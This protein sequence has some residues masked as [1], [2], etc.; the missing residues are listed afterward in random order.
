MK[1]LLYVLAFVIGWFGYSAISRHPKTEVT[2]RLLSPITGTG[3]FTS[4]GDATPKMSY[5]HAVVPTG[6]HSFEDLRASISKYPGF[7][8]TYASMTK[9]GEDQLMYTGYL[10]NGKI[11]WT[12]KKV[13]IR[14]DEDIWTDGWMYIRARCGNPLSFGPRAPVLTIQPNDLDELT[15][16]T[17]DAPYPSSPEQELFV[18]LSGP[19]P[20]VMT[21]IT[22]YD[23]G[24]VSF[25]GGTW[26]SGGMGGGFEKP[27][28]TPEP[29]VLYMILVGAALVLVIKGG[30]R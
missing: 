8:L 19:S 16:E 9:F 21:P 29:S 17:S 26:S 15:P 12:K 11:Y 6:I 23:Q 14:G 30:I 22:Y 3:V 25:Y 2:A 27:V 28:A 5:G 24:G 10:E 4:Q 13:L 1:K 18:P 7:D 20:A